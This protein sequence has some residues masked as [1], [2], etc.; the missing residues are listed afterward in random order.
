MTFVNSRQWKYIE[1][2]SKNRLS[3]NFSDGL[4]SIKPASLESISKAILI[5]IFLD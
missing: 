3:G 4:L 5:N 2:N 1:D